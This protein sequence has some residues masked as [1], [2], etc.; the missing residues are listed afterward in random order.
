[1]PD[2]DDV[3]I[4][5]EFHVNSSTELTPESAGI[6]REHCKDAKTLLEWLKSEYSSSAEF[7]KDFDLIYDMDVQIMVRRTG[8]VDPNQMTIDGAPAILKPQITGV[9]W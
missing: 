7:L 3:D 8:D 9:D 5:I 1:M 6:P 4:K 2:D